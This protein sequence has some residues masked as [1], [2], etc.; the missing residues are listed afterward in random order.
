[1]SDVEPFIPNADLSNSSDDDNWL[2]V[3]RRAPQAPASEPLAVPTRPALAVP[4]PAPALAAPA[5]PAPAL[6]I[7]IPAQRS[8]SGTSC[9]RYGSGP[10]GRF[11]KRSQTLKGVTANTFRRWCTTN[12][13]PKWTCEVAPSAKR[14]PYNCTYTEEQ[15]HQIKYV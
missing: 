8:R 11:E 5:A 7:G 12:Q 9:A 15:G 14:Q 1:M 13:P 2:A 6:A 3:G 4:V 10:G